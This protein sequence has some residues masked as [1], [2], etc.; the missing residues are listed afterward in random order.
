MSVRRIVPN[1]PSRQ[2]ELS[3]DFY[4]KLLGLQAAMD[5]G[6]IATY[7]ST[8]NPTAQISVVRA[9]DDAVLTPTIT[10]E[11][12]DVDRVHTDAVTSGY[13]IVY[14]LTDEPWGVR[15]FGVEDPNGIVINVMRHIAKPDAK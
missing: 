7:V 14:P 1:I 3:R 9:G 10:V 8:T 11:V 13:R 4:V 6:W 5:M 2:P 12:E 15:R